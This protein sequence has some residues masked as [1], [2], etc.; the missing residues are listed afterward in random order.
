MAEAEARRL[1]ECFVILLPTGAEDPRARLLPRRHQAVVVV[2]VKERA[3]L[4]THSNTPSI[5]Q[6]IPHNI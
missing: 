6:S 5:H 1:Q 4:H 3:I 2:V